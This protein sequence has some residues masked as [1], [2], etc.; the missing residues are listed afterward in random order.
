MEKTSPKLGRK[1]LI[2]IIVAAVLVLAIVGV[3]LYLFVPVKIAVDIDS[4][5]YVGTDVVVRDAADGQHKEI[6]KSDGNGGISDKPFKILAFTDTHF[7]TYKKKGSFT[8]KYML[9]N[10]YME[11]P[12]LVVFVGDVVTSATN[13]ARAKQL[14]EVMEKL[15]VY[16]AAVLGNH[17]GDNIRSISRKEFVELY[18]SY[19]HCLISA[20]EKFTSGGEKVWGNGNTQIDILAADGSIAQTL[21]FI[22]SG[23]EISDED[24]K[25]F[26]VEKGSYD[27]V[28]PSQI[29]WYSER[30]ATLPEGTRSTMFLHIPFPEYADALNDV[31]RKVDGTFDYGAVSENGTKA[32]F[33]GALEGVASP[34]YNSGLFDAILE[35]GST[36]TVVCGHDH[37]NDFRIVYKGVTL[38]YNR[39]SGYSSYNA[40]SKNKARELG[41]GATVYTVNADGSIEFTDIL[42]R[43]RFDVSE[44]YKL[45]K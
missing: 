30:V 33:G 41:Q 14:A 17:E 34:K 28:K 1:K 19:P 37:I 5:R 24:A 42:N 9:E 2:M 36:K 31:P 23:N 43:E 12:D 45:Y 11:K 22:D 8:V 25:A 16:W 10:I 26:G 21:F 4:V 40:Y 27:Y 6:F 20:E 7:D 3:M 29:K 13:R 35:G 15:G 39:A 18:A 38:C 44:A 32:L